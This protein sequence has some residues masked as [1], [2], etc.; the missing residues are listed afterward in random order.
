MYKIDPTFLDREDIAV[1]LMF[2]VLKRLCHPISQSAYVRK[3]KSQTGIS[4]K[5][6]IFSIVNRVMSSKDEEASISNGS[7]DVYFIENSGTTGS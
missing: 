5:S 1:Y 2:W 3:I 6:N 7:D 4:I